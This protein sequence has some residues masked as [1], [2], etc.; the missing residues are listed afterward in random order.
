MDEDLVYPT[1]IKPVARRLALYFRGQ[2][3]VSKAE[4]AR[5]GWLLY[6]YGA[7]AMPEDPPMLTAWD[8]NSDHAAAAFLEGLC[9][10]EDGVTPDWQKCLRLAKY[11]FALVA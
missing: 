2:A 1:D 9:G 6:G 11:I 7:A 8:G 4:L 3:H 5:A 10:L